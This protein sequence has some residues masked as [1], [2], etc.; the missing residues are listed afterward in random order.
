M[1]ERKLKVRI[2]SLCHAL[3]DGSIRKLMNQCNTFLRKFQ[4]NEWS[5]RQEKICACLRKEVNRVVRKTE[6]EYWKDELCNNVKGSSD[7]WK[8]VKQMTKKERR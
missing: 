8:I 5:R 4:K 7:F 3:M 6:A 1:P 2:E